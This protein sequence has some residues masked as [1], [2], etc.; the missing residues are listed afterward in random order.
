[1]VL[2]YRCCGDEART[3][4]QQMA[5]LTHT[6]VFYVRNVMTTTFRQ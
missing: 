3:A 2:S 1:M 5:S 6:S 4:S